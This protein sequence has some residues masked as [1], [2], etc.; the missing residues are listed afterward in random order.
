MSTIKTC[1]VALF[2]FS[3][4]TT[5]KAQTADEIIAKHIDAIGGKDK[6]AQINSVYIEAQQKRWATSLLQKLTS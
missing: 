6:L 5:I 4:V 1:I 3:S 2:A